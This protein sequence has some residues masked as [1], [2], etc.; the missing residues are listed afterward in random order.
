MYKTTTSL[1]TYRKT[2]FWGVNMGILTGNEYIRRLNN[3]KNEIWFDGKRIEG[4]IS[5]HPAFKGIIQS[6]ATLYD[7][8]HKTELL[9]KMTFM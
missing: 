7:L 1:I 9:D 2:I 6:K 3:L 8:Q 4:L 5:E